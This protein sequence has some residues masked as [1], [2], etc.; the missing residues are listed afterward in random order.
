MSERYTERAREAIAFAPE[1]ARRLRHGYVGT[2]HLLLGL[3]RADRGTAA[4]VLAGLNVTLE[5]VRDEVARIVGSSQEPTSGR[6]PLTPRAEKVMELAL[7]EALSGGQGSAGSEHVLLA[8]AREKTGVAARVL[9]D[10]GVDAEMIHREV[11]RFVPAPPSPF[12]A[13]VDRAL[14]TAAADAQAEGGRAMDDGDLLIALSREP[15]RVTARALVALG[16]QEPAL[17]D[18]IRRART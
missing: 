6:L 5:G 9:R 7:H 8:L 10:F 2:E 18:A 3:L 4:R 14:A 1:E 16:I 15:D 12:A 11:A 13:W 17:R